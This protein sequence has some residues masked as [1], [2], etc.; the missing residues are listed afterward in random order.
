MLEPIKKVL[1]KISKVLALDIHYYAKNERWQRL[2][3][4]QLLFLVVFNR[5]YLF[6]YILVLLN[7]FREIP[8]IIGIIHYIISLYVA[9]YLVLY[10]NPY[11]KLYSNFKFT[12]L[13]RK[14]IYSSGTLLLL[15]IVSTSIIFE[16]SVANFKASVHRFSPF[17]QGGGGGGNDNSRDIIFQ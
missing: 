4:Y 2:Q 3:A 6:F 1:H 10:Y 8:S 14:V 5:A 9:V 17:H 11:L 15:S 16:K 13:D 12:D 7:L